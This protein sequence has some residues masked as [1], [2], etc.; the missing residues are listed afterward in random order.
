MRS[1][2]GDIVAD[3]CGK[4]PAPVVAAKSPGKSH[5]AAVRTTCA[6]GHSHPSKTEARACAVVHARYPDACVFR[7]A[8]LPLWC[9]TPTDA[10]IPHYVNIDFVVVADGGDPV[11]FIDAKCGKR[12]RDWERGRAAAQATYGIA[13]EELEA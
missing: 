4:K 3:E 7:N 2:T 6:R 9:L 12:S 10:G 5:Y 11:A 13:V 1:P 8:R